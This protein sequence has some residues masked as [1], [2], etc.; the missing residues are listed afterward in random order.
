MAYILF[1]Y[2]VIT[3][4]TTK[5][6]MDFKIC[7][8]LQFNEEG[9]DQYISELLFPLGTKHFGYG[10]YVENLELH[11]MV[12]VRAL[13]KICAKQEND[14]IKSKE[15]AEALF[16]FLKVINYW[17]MVGMRYVQRRGRD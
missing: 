16:I 8:Q 11:G 9:A 5:V 4:V 3:S 6:I 14:E 7:F 1:Q 2:Q 10:C 17:L 13:V 15:T 12:M